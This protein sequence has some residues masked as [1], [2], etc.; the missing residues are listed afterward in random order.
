MGISEKTAYLKGLMDG[1]EID[2]S[3]KE[4]KMFA[5]IIDVLDEVASD[6]NM[7]EE[8]SQAVNDEL[9][10]IEDGMDMLDEDVSELFD[11]LEDECECECCDDDEDEEEDQDE[12]L[13]DDLDDVD[14]DETYYEL[15]CPTCGEEIVVDEEM[16]DKGEMKCPACGED[17]EFDLSDLEEEEEK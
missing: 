11:I 17:L 9:D 6:V 8:N 7:L 4:G 1:L 12:D 5:A 14:D 15:V 10:L 3:T 13:D 16:L 2:K